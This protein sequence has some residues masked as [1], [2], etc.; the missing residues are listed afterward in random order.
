MTMHTRRVISVL[1]ILVFLSF[2][3]PTISVQAGGVPRIIPK[4][5]FRNWYDRDKSFYKGYDQLKRSI[6]LLTSFKSI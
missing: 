3:T 5:R 2:S 1:T 6:K 4:L